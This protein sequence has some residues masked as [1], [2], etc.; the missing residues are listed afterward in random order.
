[1]PEPSRRQFPVNDGISTAPEDC[2]GI[3]VQKERRTKD[4]LS[5]G[6]RPGK[7]GGYQ[8]KLIKK[9]FH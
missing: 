4:E 9:I 3:Q 8:Y 7:S 2:G 5:R 1:V 6:P